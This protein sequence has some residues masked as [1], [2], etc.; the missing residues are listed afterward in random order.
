MFTSDVTGTQIA[1]AIERYIGHKYALGGAPGTDGKSPWDCSSCVN[2]VLGHDF[3]YRL[4]G[5]KTAYT[6]ATH[7]PVV[8]SYVTWT[9]ASTVAKPQAG[10]LVIWPGIGAAGHIGIAVSSTEMVSALN[11]G[12]G[13]MKTPIASTHSGPPMFRRIKGAAATTKTKTTSIFNPF[14][15][16]TNVNSFAGD[17]LSADLWE[18][19]GLILAGAILII[20][21]LVVLGRGGA[22]KNTSYDPEVRGFNQGRRAHASG[23]EPNP[24]PIHE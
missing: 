18:R 14:S 12:L 6:G 24:A 16:L 11:P 13:T 19:A 3:D 7:G 23:I 20:I 10:D 8:V 1:N 5:M 21:G 4:P 22:L 2:W 15:A 17:L 9:G